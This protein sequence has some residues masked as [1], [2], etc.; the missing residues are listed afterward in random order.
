MPTSGSAPRKGH[1]IDPRSFCRGRGVRVLPLS[2]TAQPRNRPRSS[3]RRRSSRRKSS[4]Y[5]PARRGAPI[6]RRIPFSTRG[7]HHHKHELHRTQSTG[8]AAQV[9]R[10]GRRGLGAR[11]RLRRWLRTAGWV[12]KR[13]VAA[14]AGVRAADAWIVRLELLGQ[15]AA[16]AGVAIAAV[17]VAAR[18]PATAGRR[19]CQRRRTGNRLPGSSLPFDQTSILRMSRLARVDASSRSAIS[20]RSGT[21]ESAT[22]TAIP[23]A[24]TRSSS[25]A[26]RRLASMASGKARSSPAWTA[27]D[28]IRIR[29][30][31]SISRPTTAASRT[32]CSSCAALRSSEGSAREV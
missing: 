18:P 25:P 23:D 21:C 22:A 2:S 13:V 24:R 26:V 17:L 8:G 16:I 4:C 32:W 19:R 20:S 1:A 28:A 11:C 29:P 6:G 30:G 15:V 5:S 14:V 31:W 27:S 3:A 10:P 7:A 9:D 12:T